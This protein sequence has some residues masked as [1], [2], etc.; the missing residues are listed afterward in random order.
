MEVIANY[1]TRTDADWNE[2]LRQA[3]FTDQEAKDELPDKQGYRY[4][5]W[6]NGH[7]F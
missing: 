3:T 5:K 2:I 6:E 7:S 4:R 1:L